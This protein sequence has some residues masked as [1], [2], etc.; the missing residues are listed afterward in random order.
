MNTLITVWITVTLHNDQVPCARCDF[1]RSSSTQ[2]IGRLLSRLT[3]VTLTLSGFEVE[4]DADVSV[5][6]DRLIDV[7]VCTSIHR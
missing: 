3:T 4:P 6:K 7:F 1:D 2:W 5:G